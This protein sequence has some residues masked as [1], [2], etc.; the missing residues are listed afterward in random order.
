MGGKTLA[1]TTQAM[2]VKKGLFNHFKLA[3]NG[4]A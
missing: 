2:Y 4:A 1:V 3:L